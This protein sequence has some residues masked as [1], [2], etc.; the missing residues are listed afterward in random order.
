MAAL[1]LSGV[2]EGRSGKVLFRGVCVSASPYDHAVLRHLLR[3]SMVGDR[4]VAKRFLQRV[5]GDSDSLACE[6]F[7][8]IKLV[9]W[10]RL[11]NYNAHEAPHDNYGIRRFHLRHPHAAAYHSVWAV[12]SLR[13][14]MRRER[15]GF[16]Y[17]GCK[18][19]QDHKDHRQLVLFAGLHRAARASVA[20]FRIPAKI[21]DDPLCSMPCNGLR[22]S[23]VSDMADGCSFDR[24]QSLP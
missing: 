17:E 10:N 11:H 15:G 8:Y 16:C 1:G 7:Q 18:L 14:F 13:G 3:C 4:N 19:A 9:F 6:P 23:G 24:D 12:W 21:L 20:A 2:Q 5:A 22:N